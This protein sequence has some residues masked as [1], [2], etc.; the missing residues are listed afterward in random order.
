VVFSL[1]EQPWLPVLRKSG[2]ANI[3]PAQITEDLEADPVI[4]I[5][6]P[7]AD[8]RLASLEFLI[9]LLV[10]ACP[11]E[12]PRGWTKWWEN[13]PSPEVL[14]A[15]FA[16]LADAFNLDGPG[17]RFM[18]DFENIQADENAIS[19]LLIEAPGERTLERNADLLIKRGQVKKLS[20]AAAAMALFTLQIYAP[21]GG[22]GNRTGLRGGGP[23]TTLAIPP[24]PDP[25]PLWHLLWANTP[26]YTK[27]LPG[28]L[29]RL[30]PWL[31]PTITSDNNRKVE[32]E[33][34]HDKLAFWGVPRRIWLDFTKAE[35]GEVCDLTG[36]ADEVL[37]R[38][39]RQRPY[40]AN[41]ENF[42]HPLSPH[43]KQKPQ[44]QIWL[45]VH[46]QPGGIGYRHFL[47]LIVTSKQEGRLQV[48]KSI[49]TFRADR[50]RECKTNGTMFWRVLA[51]GFDMD[52]M[53]ARSFV[54]AEMPVYEP[55]NPER[56]E[57]QDEVVV[58]LV[59]GATEA[60]NILR[61]ALRMALFSD[62]AKPDT[63]AGLFNVARARFWAETET[64]FY[65]RAATA[66][67]TEEPQAITKSFLQGISPIVRRLF[68]EHAPIVG[69][70]H[71]ARI[72]DAADYLS[73]SLRGYNKGPNQRHRRGYP[74]SGNALFDALGLPRPEAKPKGKAA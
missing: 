4:A 74:K 66:A 7:R 46:P 17:P 25:L 54:E 40:G 12:T 31:A 28:E 69:S 9:G 63:D 18:Q 59:K 45:P 16:P 37:V 20:R 36:N 38:S 39:W 22:A 72:A 71:P 48:A 73:L 67:S 51:A 2:P 49:A 53:K 33:N 62:G 68:D 6:W 60:A 32:R 19:G 64:A 3:R 41:Y 50:M 43:Y 70:D 26:V 61:S 14:A 56:R 13:P 23:L 10:V 24:G 30:L 11:P 65:E 57:I 29:P 27:P 35:S 1:L 21:A 8:F 15:G 55:D 58:K 52:N 47:G 34:D 5:N 42:H 44:D